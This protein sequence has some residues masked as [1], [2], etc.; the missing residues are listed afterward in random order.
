MHRSSDSLQRQ[1]NHFCGGVRHI[2][3]V[4]ICIG[5]IL[6]A[7][8]NIINVVRGINGKFDENKLRSGFL[9]VVLGWEDNWSWKD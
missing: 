8:Y 3:V 9:P 5:R 4:V 7:P 1:E 6:E 2:E